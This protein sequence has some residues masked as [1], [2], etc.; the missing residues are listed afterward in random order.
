MESK[1]EPRRTVTLTQFYSCDKNW[2]V[3]NEYGAI[4]GHVFNMTLD[5]ELEKFLVTDYLAE[6]V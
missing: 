2:Y 4:I 5:A 1:D 3:Y 6:R